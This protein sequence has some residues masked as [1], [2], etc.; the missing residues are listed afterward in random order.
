[1]RSDS[2]GV[3]GKLNIQVLNEYNSLFAHAHYTVQKL[4]WK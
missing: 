3:K 2:Y 1:M 4:D